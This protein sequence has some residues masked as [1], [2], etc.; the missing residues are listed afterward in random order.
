[1][2]EAASSKL[3][4]AISERNKAEQDYSGARGDLVQYRRRVAKE[5][6]ELKSENF[7]L[8]KANS[9]SQASYS[10]ELAQVSEKAKTLEG[11]K[12]TMRAETKSEISELKSAAAANN[13]ARAAKVAELE[14]LLRVKTKISPSSRAR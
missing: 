13:D 6:V 4:T 9:D 14:R 2:A 10:T 5:I 1:M 3:S 11:E 12:E 8:K 7:K